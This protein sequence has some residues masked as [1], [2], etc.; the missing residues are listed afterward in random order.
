MRRKAEEVGK[1]YW[2]SFQPRQQY[3]VVRENN[4]GI[5]GVGLTS[6]ISNIHCVWRFLYGRVQGGRFSRVTLGVDECRVLA[7][8]VTIWMFD[9]LT[10]VFKDVESIV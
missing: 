1:F 7:N 5:A 9:I 10:I 6:A 4:F 8:I 2:K 3:V